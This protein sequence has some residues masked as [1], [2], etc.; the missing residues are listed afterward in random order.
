MATEDL[1][2]TGNKS[3]VVHVWRMPNVKDKNKA[4]E[5]VKVG[6]LIFPHEFYFWCVNVRA[7]VFKHRRPKEGGVWPLPNLQIGVIWRE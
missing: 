7:V 4:L 1:L 3:T 5:L 6:L 2:I